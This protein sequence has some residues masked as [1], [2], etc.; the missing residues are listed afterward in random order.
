MNDSPFRIEGN[1]VFSAKTGKL[2]A[3]LN[4]D[5]APVFQKG[6]AGAYSKL[7]AEYLA[8]AGGEERETE[9]QRNGETLDAEPAQSADETEPAQSAG[10]PGGTNVFVGSIPAASGTAVP[11]REAPEKTAADFD[12]AL[13]PDADLP[14]FDPMLGVET[15]GFRAFV[16]KHRLAQNAVAALV[17]RLENNK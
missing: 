12:V 2:V 11:K 15:P 13:I 7:L 9:K 8:A 10:A 4:D 17:R 6:Y 5:G 1:Q 14:D 3:V 16:A